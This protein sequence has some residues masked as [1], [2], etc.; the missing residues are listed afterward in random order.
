M[1]WNSEERLCR[2]CLEQGDDEVTGE[3]F[4]PCRCK[5]GTKY[6]HRRC[7]DTWRSTGMNPSNLTRCEVCHYKYRFAGGTGTWRVQVFY[8]G[9]LLAEIV[10]FVVVALLVGYALKESK[11]LDTFDFGRLRMFKPESGKGW[12]TAGCLFNCFCIGSCAVLVTISK[13]VFGLH[14][15]SEAPNARKTRQ[16]PHSNWVDQGRRERTRRHDCCDICL[17]G[18]YP[19]W[20]CYCPA[21]DCC[22][23]CDNC[24]NCDC[25]SSDCGCDGCCSGGGGG[26]ADICCVVVIPLLMVVAVVIMII[27]AL[28]FF[29][30]IF[31]NIFYVV[32]VHGSYLRQRAAELYA[33]LEYDASKDA[34]AESEDAGAEAEGPPPPRIAPPVPQVMIGAA[35]TGES[36]VS[37]PWQKSPKTNQIQP[38]ERE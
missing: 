37:E 26:D 24:C 14:R 4:A 23:A 8:L 10:A 6:V 16:E 11:F 18:Y 21:E 13:C 20:G 34:G 2:I 35:E 28:V 9:I 22:F 7:L 30:A 19:F 36:N 1:A 32:H 29:W 38:V 17:F 5:G 33:V 3:L 15:G 25:S 31:F 12:F 27:G